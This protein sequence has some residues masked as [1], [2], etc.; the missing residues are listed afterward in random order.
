MTYFILIVFFIWLIALTNRLSESQEEIKTL[1]LKTDKLLN[2]VLKLEIKPIPKPQEEEDFIEQVKI[3]KQEEVVENISHSQINANSFVDKKESNEEEYWEEDFEENIETQKSSKTIIQNNSVSKNNFEN[4]FLGN[5]FNIIGGLAII[6]ALG[7]FIKA[8]SSYITFT[9]LMKTII[10]LIS[11]FGLIIGSYKIKDNKLKV[12]SEIMLGTGF[13]ALFVTII[14]TTV[15]F[16][17]FTVPVCITLSVILLLFSYFIADK[18]KTVSM[19]SISLIGGYLIAVMLQSM[20]LNSFYI[21]NYLIFLNLLS[22]FYVFKNYE[23]NKINI[24][25]LFVATM[26]GFVNIFNSKYMTLNQADVISIAYPISLWAI[27]LV[28]DYILRWKH[29]DKYDIFGVLNWVN[30]GSV[31][32]LTQMI[33]GFSEK[34][35]SAFT[36][37]GLLVGYDLLVCLSVLKQKKNYE[38]Y[39]HV[40]IVIVYILVFLIPSD[41]IRVFVFALISCLLLLLSKKLSKRYLAIFSSMFLTTSIFDIF[42]IKGICYDIDINSYVPIINER[43]LFFLMP[44]FSCLA[45]LWIFKDDAKETIA[46]TMKLSFISLIF[47]YLIFEINAFATWISGENNSSLIA[48]KWLTYSI[49]G[50]NYALILK[51]FSE[52]KK[53]IWLNLISY[54]VGILSALIFVVASI[55]YTTDVP[56]FNMRMVA[57]AFAILTVYLFSKWENKPNYN[58]LSVIFGFIVLTSETNVIAN[59]INYNEPHLL[60]VSWIIYAGILS[61]IGIAKD[62]KILKN[63]GICL[64]LLTVV[65]II[66]NTMEYAATFQKSL[67]FVVLGLIFMIIS[68]CYNKK[69]K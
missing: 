8:I 14:L 3:E 49:L 60:S 43:T 6:V 52:F 63:S 25:N 54:F 41:I 10:G 45:S 33:F 37:L 2:K 11:G 56:F 1:K 59:I 53:L 7:I 42:F 4:L 13:T 27:Y 32:L 46:N 68:F 22:I 19:I 20:Q 34:L 40:L 28:V 50:F 38:T 30:F 29:N 12:F 23:R 24:L 62:N 16:K 15:L 65:K 31:L 44:I 69:K 48:I 47:L 58:Y 35:Y 17:T 9:P 18:Q 66:M 5:L 36:L 51:K 61:L 55:L 26:F 64:S 67:T 39:V 57:T 21:W